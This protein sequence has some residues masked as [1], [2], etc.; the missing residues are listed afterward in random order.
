MTTAIDSPKRIRALV[1]HWGFDSSNPHGYATKINT[2]IAALIITNLA[3][4]MLETI[5]VIYDANAAF[6]HF[7]DQVSVIM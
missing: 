4:L 5:P 7:F 3:A 6:F 2:F 1:Y